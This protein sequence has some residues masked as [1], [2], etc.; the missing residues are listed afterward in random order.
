ME[1]TPQ[2]VRW[3]RISAILI[4]L[5]FGLTILGNASTDAFTRQYLDSAQKEND[6]H[7]MGMPY[8]PGHFCSGGEYPT[9][10][11]CEGH[12]V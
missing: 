10:D 7:T 11:W 2:Q 5:P 12:G 4:L 9:F 8:T 1:K 3:L 6:V